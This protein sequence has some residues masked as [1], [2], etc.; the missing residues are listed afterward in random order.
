MPSHNWHNWKVDD[1]SSILSGLVVKLCDVFTGC[2][3]AGYNDDFHRSRQR[4]SFNMGF[5]LM[6]ISLVYFQ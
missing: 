4:L 3:K 6:R 2:K 1:G 5:I